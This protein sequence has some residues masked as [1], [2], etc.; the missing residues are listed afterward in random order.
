MLYN[1][2]QT[3]TTTTRTAPRSGSGLASTKRAGLAVAAVAAAL[4]AGG[5]VAGTAEAAMEGEAVVECNGAYNTIEV[6]PRVLSDY[7]NTP[8]WTATRVWIAAWNGSTW[9]WDA[10]AWKIEQASEQNSPIAMDISRLE[11]QQISK[12]DGYYYVYVQSYM[13]DGAGWYGGEGAYTRT[14]TQV[15]PSVSHEPDSR[16]AASYCTL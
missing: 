2:H 15:T 4:A 14:Y 16:E 5:L 11:T 3:T 13:W 10:Q 12:G 7:A 6:T 1:E 8:Q 9:E